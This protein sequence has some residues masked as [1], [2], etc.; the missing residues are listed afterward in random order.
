MRRLDSGV[1]RHF[2]VIG[3]R[4]VGIGVV[5]ITL[6]VCAAVVAMAMPETLS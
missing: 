1:Q 2:L 3:G 4:E 6:L 5:S